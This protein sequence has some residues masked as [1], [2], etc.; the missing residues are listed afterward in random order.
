M[1]SI[2][3]FQ[4]YNRHIVLPE[5]GVEGQI[6][7]K[8]AKVMVIGA[9]GL[10]CPVLQYLAAAGVGNI[11]IVDFDVVSISNLQRQI[12][13]SET[14]I[15]KKKALCAAEAI[16]KI[17]PLVNVQTFDVRITNKNALDLLSDYDIVVDGTDNFTTRYIINDACYLLKKPLVFGAIFKFEGQ[18]TVFNL[19]PESPT[20]RSIY[21]VAPQP[22]TVPNCSE[23]GVIGILPGIIGCIQASEVIK[24]ITGIGQ[25]L[26][27]RIF[28]YDN[29][30]QSVFTIDIRGGS[31]N[32]S[33][34]QPTENEFFKYDY[35]F[36]CEIDSGY[37][38]KSIT[39][40]DFNLNYTAYRIVDIREL[41]EQPKLQIPSVEQ[42]PLST[43]NVGSFVQT[44]Q[45]VIVLCQKGIRSKNL[46][47][48]LLSLH[49]TLDVY[50][51]EGG[52]E[53]L[54]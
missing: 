42:M 35:N 3:E 12:L 32:T 1:L 34:I 51:L 10:G 11:G 19:T 15:G 47:I 6:K 52:I 49:P 21:P 8:N 23:I 33:K 14:Q 2:I 39:A 38:I 20:Y 4:R 7:L 28:Y 46:I 24:V 45:P 41:Y 26:D 36:N 25:P 13:Y 17:N 16:A 37:E 5:L 31:E 48:K 18:V 43:F 53:S 22:G 54:S 50:N 27:G 9:G 40:T 44:D 29:L 30:D